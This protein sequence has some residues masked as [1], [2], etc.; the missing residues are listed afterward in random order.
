MM[1]ILFMAI[2]VAVCS[3]APFTQSTD[4]KESAV[5]PVLAKGVE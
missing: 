5:S 2:I 1:T 3:N 4:D